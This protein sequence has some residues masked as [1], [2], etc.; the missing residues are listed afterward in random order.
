VREGLGR[1]AVR[2]Q[3]LF[4]DLEA[5]AE[6]L[7]ARDF[8]GEV[9]ERTRIEVGKIRVVDRLRGALGHPVQVCCL[10]AGLVHGRLA[11]VGAGWL[12]LSETPGREALVALDAVTSLV[13]L[14]ALS[15][16]P[17]KEGKVASRLDLRH[18]LRGIVR[19]RASLQVVLTDGTRFEGTFDRVGAD[20]V[21]LAEHPH[22]EPRRPAAVQRVRTMPL[23]ALAVVRAG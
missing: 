3:R 8:E 21:E 13:G 9:A 19:E 12:L 4:A 1:D 11:E 22:E 18:A 17:G 20:F 5:Q 10:G 7:D 23:A 16:A 15:A 6:E 2:W 14:G